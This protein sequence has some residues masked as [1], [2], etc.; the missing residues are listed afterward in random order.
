MV[1]KMAIFLSTDKDI[2][3]FI[4]LHNKRNK[5]KYNTLPMILVKM[6]Q[7]IVGNS[8]ESSQDRQ[9]QEAVP[10]NK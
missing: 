2:L 4:C 10:K 3:T 1:Y 6:L 9:C 8:W 5:R 7:T